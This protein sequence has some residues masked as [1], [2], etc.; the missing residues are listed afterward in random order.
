MDGTDTH[1]SNPAALRVVHVLRRGA[2]IV[3]ACTL[4]ATAVAV[5]LALREPPLYRATSVVLLQNGGVS[6]ELLGTRGV[7]VYQD[8]DRFAATQTAIAMSPDVATR[9]AA[10]QPV[11]G[12][13]GYE[14]LGA[15]A[16][17]PAANSDLLLFTATWS[18]AAGATAIA[19]AYARQYVSD[20]QR[21]DTA[22]LV[23]ARRKL[24]A[25]ID[26]LTESEL[27]RSQLVDR[28]VEQAQL[29]QTQEE[30]RTA[31]AV[32]LRR[33]LGAAQI[34]PQPQRAA[35]LGVVLGLMLGIV[36]AFVREALDTRVRSAREI[37]DQLGLPLL[38]RLPSPPRSLR[39]KSRLVMLSRRTGAEAEAFR[40]LRT[41]VEFANL[42]RGAR[43]IMVTSATESEGKSTTAANL[44]VALMRAGQRVALV[45][46]DLRRPTLGRF[47]GLPAD[48]PGLVSVA[49]GR[50]P[51][52]S[53]LHQV[54]GG[55]LD[56][57]GVRRPGE[58]GWP[59]EPGGDGSLTLL[60]SGPVPAD[61]GEFLATA[62][63]PALLREVSASSDVVVVDTPPLLSVGD[64]LALSAAIDALIVVVRAGAVKRA[65]LEELRRALDTCP[66][67]K[68]GYVVT[69]AELDESFTFSGHIETGYYGD[70]KH[71]RSPQREDAR[72]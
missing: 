49:L 55:E 15:I 13:S 31:N 72:A 41:N 47:F 62:G 61:P 51:L 12:L 2:W 9:V 38:A 63:L 37:G 11:Q 64:G 48:A 27:R 54:L 57:T 52:R 39:S 44:A 67:I 22:A 25:R 40:M 58:H 21:L 46:L 14:A 71:D 43:S 18:T 68:L 35:L 50:A 3:V 29:L 8:P 17:A 16:V 34:Q 24:E 42:D 59:R 26:E 10:L 6:V 53:A 7:G 70:G 32:L 23:N 4:L 56:L 36:L 19:N 65:E 20:R 1:S 33:S 5:A 45:D 69:A 60:P 66:T 30:L 28:L